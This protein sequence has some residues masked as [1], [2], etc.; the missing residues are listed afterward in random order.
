ME[1]IS[2]AKALEALNKKVV[3]DKIWSVD[4]RNAIEELPCIEITLTQCKDCKSYTSDHYCE[5][6][7]SYVDPWDFC[8]NWR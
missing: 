8:S 5:S 3:G 4:A 6:F 1:L 2:R 7:D